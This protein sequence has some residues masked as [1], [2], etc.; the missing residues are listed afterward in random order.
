MHFRLLILC[1]TIAFISNAQLDTA[2]LSARLNQQ[3]D[4]F[5]K[6]LAFVLYKDG[7]VMYKKE[8]GKLNIKS[9]EQIGASSQW[10][11]AALLLTYVQEGKISLDDKV[12]QYL[13]IFD[14]YY[15]GFITLRHCL[16]HNTGIKTEGK[17]FQKSKFKSLEDEVNDYASKKD[18]QTNAGTEFRYSN[19]G[20]SIAGRVLEVITKR[21]FDR[22][23][24]ERI[25]RPLGM[26]N[27]TFTNEDYNDAIDPSTGARSS[28]ADLSNFLAMLL[29]KGT[30]NNKQ[31]LNE[32][33]VATLLSLQA[34]AA[35][36]K[37]APKATEGYNLALGSWILEDNGAGKALA[38]T[39]PSLAGTWP[40]ID[41]CRNYAFVMVTKQLSTDPPRQLYLDLK[42]MVDENIRPNCQ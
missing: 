10:L 37:G 41:L 3:K 33:S 28:A 2:S 35:A 12:G 25:I 40:I 24:Q 36:I 21:S 39:S 1:S 19:A 8:L 34:E 22:L 18:I 7:K 29:N 15:K 11:T 6:D 13:P 20:Y 32:A 9:Q 38:Y 26:K 17:I 30:F 5:G 31:V 4:K 14:K 42:S 23:M 16:T 27:T